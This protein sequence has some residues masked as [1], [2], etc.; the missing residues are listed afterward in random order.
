M[1]SHEALLEADHAQPVGEVTV[2]EDDPPPLAD[3]A[4]VGVSE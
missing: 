4:E 3:D 2:K 1:A